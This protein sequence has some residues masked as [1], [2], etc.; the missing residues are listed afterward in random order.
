ML[1]RL[2]LQP[3][4]IDQLPLHEFLHNRNKIAEK[5]KAENDAQRKQQQEQ[6]KN[7]SR[8]NWRMPKM[9]KWR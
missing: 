1:D 8:S 2:S 4:E 9:P 7:S 5:I 6:D 3:S